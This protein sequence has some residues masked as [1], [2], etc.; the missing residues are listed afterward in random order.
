[1]CLGISGSGYADRGPAGLHGGKLMVAERKPWL[2][3][4]LSRNSV[5]LAAAFG[6]YN[7]C[8]HT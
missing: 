6:R 4:Q 3:Y 5:K 7:R 2:E 1:M 8:K